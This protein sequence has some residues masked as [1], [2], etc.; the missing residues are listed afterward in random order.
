MNVGEIGG[1]YRT[2]GIKRVKNR[3]TNE[4]DEEKRW[5]YCASTIVEKW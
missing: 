4:N 3:E 1:K 2:A 5:K